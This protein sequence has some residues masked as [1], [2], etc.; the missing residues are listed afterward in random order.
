MCVPP[1][2][3]LLVMHVFPN[4]ISGK[5]HSKTGRNK[6]FTFRIASANEYRIPSL[7]FL[8]QMIVL[9]SWVFSVI[10]NIPLFLVRTFEK[11]KSSNS[12]VQSWPAEKWMSTVYCLAWLLLVV[13]SVGIMVVLYSKVVCTLWFK[14]NGDNRSTCQ[15]QVSVSIRLHQLLKDY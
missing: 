6:L 9:F 10:F 14:R 1:C 2:Q 5:F 12:C 15:Q 13:A 8:F 7:H 4:R 11:E 3:P